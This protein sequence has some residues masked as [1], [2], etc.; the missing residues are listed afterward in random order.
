MT[1]GELREAA[2]IA[3]TDSRP[4]CAARAAAY[5]VEIQKKFALAAACVVLALAGVAVALRFPRGGMGRVIIAS[6]VVFTGYY[7]SLMAGE[8]LADRLVIS[9][10]FAMWMANAFLLATVLLLIR[11]GRSRTA[12][13]AESLAIGN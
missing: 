7:V 9:P 13:G 6:V 10:F 3:R 4:G 11:R 2:R 1:I 8:S 12:G 5:Q